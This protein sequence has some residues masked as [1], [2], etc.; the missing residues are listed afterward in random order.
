MIT[1]IAAIAKNGVMGKGNQLP[2][3]LPEDL[4]HFK[5]AT[6]GKPV[7]MGRKTFQSLGRPLP[8]RTNIV[9]SRHHLDMPQGVEKASSLE[10]A[11]HIGLAA[12]K[13]QGGDE[14]CIVGGGDIYRQALPMIDK[15]I[16]SRVDLDVDGDTYF[17]AWDA[18]DFVLQESTPYPDATIPFTVEVYTRR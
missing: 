9:I 1:L 17:P 4:K 7:I 2:W 11:I 5:A 8:K 18:K 16:L 12:A 10:E 3:H 15:M 13:Q 14:I 6:L